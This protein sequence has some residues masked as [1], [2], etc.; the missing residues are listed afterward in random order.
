MRSAAA[1]AAPAHPPCYQRHQP[2]QTPLYRLV[3]QPL[4]TF[5]AQ[6]EA[7]GTDL[8]RFVTEEF[9]AYLECGIL[10]H[11]F[12]RLRCDQCARETVVAFSCKRRGL[13]PSCGTRRMNEAAAWLVDQVIPRV[14]VRQWVLSFPIPL[15]SLFAVHP[16]LLASVLRIIQRIIATHLIKQAHVKRGEAATGAV[17]LIQ[18]FGSAAYLNIHLHG[19]VLD[20]V[21]QTAGENEPIF[22][23]T[24]P[25][26]TAQLEALLGKIIARLMKLLTRTG[27]IIEEEGVVYLADTDPDNVLAPLQA[28]SCTYRI[29]QG[30]R[31]GQKV[32]RV[33][34]LQ[35]GQ[36]VGK[37]QRAHAYAT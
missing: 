25:P 16:E 23:E 21:Y 6:A 30:P 29:A 12:M 20:G 31:A 19:L 26:S 8:P 10:A 28:A 36:P 37:A 11:G 34:S 18:R 5:L 24:P 27:H 35:D 4:Q 14:P 17:T 9:D 33:L 2:E 7:A 3:Q 15:R 13:C 22:H 1:R 32:L